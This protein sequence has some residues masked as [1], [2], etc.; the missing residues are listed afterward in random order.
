MGIEKEG[1]K[2]GV[3]YV[4]GFFQL[5][6][7]TTKTRKKLFVTKSDLPERQKQGKKY[8]GT[9]P[10][11]R[12]QL[13]DEDEVG[14]RSSIQGT[15]D[16]SCA[17]SVTDDDGCGPRAPGVVARLMGLDS[18]PTSSFPEPYSTPYFDTQYCRTNLGYQHDHQIMY[19]GNLL[20]KAEG[21]SRNFLELKPQKQLGRP[22]EKFQTEILPPR[23]AKSIPVTHH[24][25]LSPIKSP[26]FIPTKNAA[27][28]MEAAAKIIEPGPQPPAKPPLA[29]SSTVSLKVR[30]LKEKVEAAH[31]GTFVGSSSVTSRVRDLKEKVEAS[32]KSPRLAEFSES[33][34]TFESNA[35]MYLRGQYLNKSWNG[36]VETSFRAPTD[37]EEG[38]SFKDKGK[39]VSLAIQAKV[40]VQR[41]EGLN[42]SASKSSVD[43]KEQ[44]EVKPSQRLKRQ[45][46][47]QRNLH[48]KSSGVLKQNN[49]KQNCLVDNNRL[50]SKR[51]VSN[52][53]SRKVPYG[54]S[55]YGRQK[56]LSNCTVN[57]KV[58]S[59]KLGLEVTDSGKEV[60][61]TSTNSM[62]RKKRSIDR[63]FQFEKNQVV[64][65]LSK[66]K[67]QKPVESSP[68]INSH[69]NWAEDSKKKGMD[70]VSF[71]FTAPL[72]RSNP[73]SEASC[74]ASQKSS[75]LSMDH[76]IKRVSVDSDSMK[77]S[78][79]GYNVIGGDALSI[80]L[81]QKLRELTY[82][83]HQD[84]F[85][86]GSTS[87]TS[88]NFLDLA[89]SPDSVSLMSRLHGKKEQNISF[90]DKLGVGYGSDFSSFAP[91]KL[92]PKHKCQAV[93]EMDDHRSNHIES[94]LFSCRHPSPV[95]ILE[96][97]FLTESNDSSVST[98]SNST[99][100]SKLCSSVQARA[101][102]GTRSS[103]SKNFYSVEADMELSDSVSSTSTG[104][105]GKKQA[106]TLI[107]TSR[108]GKSSSW[109]L[110]YVKEILCY[111]ELMFNDFSLGRAREIINP[112]LFN[113]LESRK[114]GLETDGVES[115]PRR[116][117][118]F[119][120]VSEC[121]DL[122]CRRYVGGG[123]RMWAKGVAMVS[124]K[125]PLAEEVYK[126]ISD[127]RGMGDSMV[128]E[129]VDKDMS[130]QFGRW[131]DFD[132]DAF[133]LG[134]EVESQIF[135]SLVDE[136]VDDILQI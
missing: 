30:E 55:T 102:L 122:R 79:I 123:Y 97:S 11:T 2:N 111:V 24:K 94:K 95:S 60:L 109:E 72:T 89:P 53:H 75:V 85:R 12:F 34:R 68:V 78:P 56:G 28:I 76:L 120:C 59:R 77:S 93:D 57:S 46:N 41:R 115:R 117:V 118:V 82:E 74:H 135:S 127:W 71:T 67:T 47:N 32:N 63:D 83:S 38:S 36:S 69:L 87:S 73:G 8:D 31:K 54:S 14:A 22:I 64:G 5:F 49:Q 10:V 18:L 103:N 15:S 92:K 88:S 104:S 9:L 52:S 86:V 100:G 132:V 25:L 105:T 66:D 134:I 96:P 80:L 61:Y 113:Q 124:R 27:Y 45:P 133:S 121:L 19:S 16:Y 7:W 101:V 90:T 136:I 65:N 29:A 35:T 37:A 51:L 70:V 114:R 48:K 58:G 17:S 99:E 81:E 33:P 44:F 84:S 128:D 6:D 3:R 26:G 116:K 110:D 131:L 106:S 20:N 42:L 1:T 130:S 40:N 108:F 23:S 112:H 39:S 4:G 107:M 125:E 62:P 50:P 91:P 126:E 13:T 119:D 43:Q 129:L 21:S 98:D